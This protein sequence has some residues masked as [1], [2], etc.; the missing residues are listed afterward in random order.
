MTTLLDFLA[1]NPIDSLTEE[2]I[3]SERLKDFKFKIKAMSGKDFDNYAKQSRRVTKKGKSD[4]DAEK[5]NMLIILNHTVEPDFRNVKALDKAKCQTPEEFINKSLLAG[6]I[7]ELSMA[8]SRLS[9]FD[10]DI[11]ELVDEVKN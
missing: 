4:L 6:E 9:G 1:D 7:N 8:I 2:V 3:I 10:Q 5:L 11:N